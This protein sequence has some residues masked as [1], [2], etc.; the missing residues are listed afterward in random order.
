MGNEAIATVLSVL[1][2]IAAVIVVILF[3]KFDVM[4]RQV[5][6]FKVKGLNERMAN[7]PTKTCISRKKTSIVSFFIMC[8]GNFLWL[9]LD[10][11]TFAR[12]L[13]F[14]LFRSMMVA[15][16]KRSN[17]LNYTGPAKETKIASHRQIHYG[18]TGGKGE[19]GNCV[20]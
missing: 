3:G 12:C 8:Y 6:V 13:T 15:R 14:C 10:L 17:L 4:L 7:I 1:I 19:G 16:M 11:D 18:W 20:T 2:A 9:C 5:S